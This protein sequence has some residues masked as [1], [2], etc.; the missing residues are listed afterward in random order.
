MPRKTPWPPEHSGS[1]RPYGTPRPLGT[2]G[3]PASPEPHALCGYRTFRTVL[4]SMDVWTYLISYLNLIW[5]T[6]FYVLI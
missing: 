2:P 6:T 3:T 5:C 4:T 1:P